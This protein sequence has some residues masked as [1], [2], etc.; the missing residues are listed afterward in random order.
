MNMAVECDGEPT[1]RVVRGAL[2]PDSQ[3]RAQRGDLQAVKRLM[4]EDV[5]K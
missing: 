5:C 2:K 4:E 3:G 1:L